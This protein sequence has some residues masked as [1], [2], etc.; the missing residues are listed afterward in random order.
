MVQD[1]HAFA[2]PGSPC[3]HIG[4]WRMRQASQACEVDEGREGHNG[5]HTWKSLNSNLNR[6]GKIVLCWMTNH[7]RQP[8]AHQDARLTALHYSGSIVA[9]LL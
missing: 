6:A 8:R 1:T 4:L 9:D 7:C 5:V 2:K 3:V